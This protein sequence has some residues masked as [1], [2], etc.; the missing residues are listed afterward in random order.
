M[1]MPSSARVAG[2]SSFQPSEEAVRRWGVR[3]DRDTGAREEVALLGDE[4]QRI[5]SCTHLPPTR[6][7]AGLVICSPL[8]AEFLHNYRKEVML[9]RSLAAAG[10]VVQRFHYRGSGNSD[11]ETEDVTFGSMLEDT[12]AAAEFFG[13]KT[14]VSDLA[15]LGTRVGGLIA[16][17]AATHFDGAPLVV[18]E[19]VLDPVTY[20]R[21][22][23]RA[24]SIRELRHD[25]RDK[26]S[27]R[28]RT[29][30]TLQELEAA[31]VVDVLGYSLHRTLY[32]SL[33]DH[34]FPEELGERPRDVLLLQLD[35]ND[36]LREEYS[37][38]VGIL[39]SSGFAVEARAIAADEHWWF[40]GNPAHSASTMRTVVSATAGWLHDR[41]GRAFA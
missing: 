25:S 20:F 36:G 31:G 5:F 19:P 39:M 21:E 41:L 23:F 22:L 30:T 27:S 34:G 32:R 16:S 14:R 1:V 33:L 6:P 10:I 40:S 26:S 12:L 2:A 4:G 37:E 17:A 35:R 11:G 3:E 15:F 9:A 18:W 7:V 24:A 38:L 8:H 29:R 13:T 28:T